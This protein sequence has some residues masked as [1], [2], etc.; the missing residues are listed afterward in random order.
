MTSVTE[1]GRMA[2]ESPV[3]SSP[4][5]HKNREFDVL[6]KIREYFK[7]MKPPGA[8]PYSKLRDVRLLTC[9]RPSLTAHFPPKDP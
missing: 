8:L 2:M 9:L 6:R 5:I 4:S 1:A 7:R 3:V